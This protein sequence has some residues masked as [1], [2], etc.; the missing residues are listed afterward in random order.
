MIKN[1]TG[2]GNISSPD[3][4]TINLIKFLKENVSKLQS[5]CQRFTNEG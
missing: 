3:E 4:E 2:T 5:L 1:I